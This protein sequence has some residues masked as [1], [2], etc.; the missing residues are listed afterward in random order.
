MRKSIYTIYNYMIKKNNYDSPLAQ[1]FQV[2]NDA[3]LCDSANV[4]T[5]DFDS[6][7]DYEW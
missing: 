4:S 5:E 6:V 2:K 1:V 3:V 7:S